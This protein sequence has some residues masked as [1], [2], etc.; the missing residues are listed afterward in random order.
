MTI[1]DYDSIADELDDLLINH[2]K[3]IQKRTRHKYKDQDIYN[4]LQRWSL[5][6]SV[7]WLEREV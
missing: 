2:A 6:I 5:G 7:R 1:K 4:I 3:I